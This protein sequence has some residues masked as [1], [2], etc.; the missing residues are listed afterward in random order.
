MGGKIRG[1]YNVLQGS[2]NKFVD[3]GEDSVN[4]ISVKLSWARGLLVDVGLGYGIIWF[5][6]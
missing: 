4:R 1:S 2:Y 3:K 6:K 5:S